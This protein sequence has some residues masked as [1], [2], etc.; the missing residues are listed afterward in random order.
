MNSKTLC[1]VL[2]GW[3]CASL[4][5]PVLA[6]GQDPSTRNSWTG[7]AEQK[8]GGLMTVWAEAK[9]AF[10]FF[11]RIPGV[12]W[13]DKALAA[14]PR[15]LAAEDI[16]SYYRVLMELAALL[17]DG[18]TAVMPPW[19]PFKP[20]T[21]SPPIEIQVVE[22]KF[23][24]ARTGE[25]DEIRDQRVYPGLEVTSVGDGVPIRK[26]FQDSILRYNS[27][28]TKQAD[29]AINLYGLLTGVKDSRVVVGVKDPD[30]TVRTV[31]LTRN[32]AERQGRPFMYRIFD[33]DSSEPVLQTKILPEGFLYV[34]ISNFD[35]EG[36]RKE[37]QELVDGLDSSRT[38][39]MIL[40]IRYNP[41]GN[42]AIADSVVSCLI[43][44][45]L[46]AEIIRVPH[47]VAAGRAWGNQPVWTELKST[48]E[49]RQGKRY[50]GPL[51]ILT[52]PATYSAAE[53]FLVPLHYSGRARLVG[54]PTAGSTGNPLRVSLPGGGNFRVVTVKCVYPDGREFVG[55]GI[56]PDL[57]VHP[58]QR[59]IQVGYDRVMAA[60]LEALKAWNL[61]R[62]G[63]PERVAMQMT[64]RKARSV[65][66]RYHIVSGRDPLAA[67]AS[68]DAARGDLKSDHSRTKKGY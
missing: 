1:L 40:D 33:W 5:G 23:V 7:T 6:Q 37:F 16:D 20:G 34:R 39:G 22:N 25:T 52:G 56:E 47:Y 18:H 55:S 19:G 67:A 62:A 12:N 60:G 3:A 27:R 31:T 41:G 36:L 48:I 49:P 57:Q 4:V 2:A 43:D 45:P 17:R 51:V 59:D 29:E 50:L 53:D 46:R 11:D 54:E 66:E 38:R 30:G 15:V 8:I 10:P 61:T 14:I 65:F 58:T 21:D 42:S 35:K 9:Y 26:H 68:L 24:V 28:G 63:I 64:G 44:Q 32:S 13:D